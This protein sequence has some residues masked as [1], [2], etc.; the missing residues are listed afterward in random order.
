[1]R[2]LGNFRRLVV[3]DVRRQRGHQ[4]QRT[5]HQFADALAIGFDAA[6][7]VLVEAAPCRR[8]AGAR[9]AGSYGR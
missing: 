2:M 1:M 4:H 3:A 7:A 5:L 6:R 9:S 8:P